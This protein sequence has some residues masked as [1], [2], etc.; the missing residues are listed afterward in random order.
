M[1]THA[2]SFGTSIHAGPNVTATTIRE[3][4]H[5]LDGRVQSF[6]CGLVAISPRLAVVR[7]EHTTARSAGGFT[8]PTG[9]HTVGFFWTGRHYNL[10]RFTAPDGSVIA[11]RFDVVDGVRITPGHVRF[12]DLL[13]DVWLAPGGAPRVEDENEVAAAG[14]AGLLSPRRRAIIDRTRRLLERDHGRI[15]AEIERGLAG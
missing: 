7:F 3:T 11:Y 5:T 2:A 9:S 10:Y 1:T 15:V 14:E 6:D 8:I 4:K 12:T 13:L